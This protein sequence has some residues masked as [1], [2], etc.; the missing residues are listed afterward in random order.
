MTLFRPAAAALLLALLL[1]GC[2]DR[3]GSRDLREAYRTSLPAAGSEV[4]PGAGDASAGDP[5][6][7]GGAGAPEAAADTLPGTAF[8]G[9]AGIIRQQ[10]QVRGAVIVEAARTASHGG[11]DRVVLEFRGNEIPSYHLEYVDR[12]VR[13]CGSGDA[14]PVPGDGWLMVRLQPARGHT[15]DYEPTITRAERRRQLD[16]PNLKGL[17]VSCDFEAVM[18]WVLG[19]GSPNRYRVMELRDPA[20]LV[21][22]V[23]H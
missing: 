19:V 14:I 1:I 22:D 23:L 18:E 20:R 9:T 13:D 11:F 21:V 12:P 10:H 3:R 15:D 2:S 16:H 5:D 17:V 7:P 6:A 4:R 8:E